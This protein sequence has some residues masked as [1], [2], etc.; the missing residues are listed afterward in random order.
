MESNN[1][2]NQV[3]DLL[4]SQLNEPGSSYSKPRLRFFNSFQEMNEADAKEMASMS[5]V[6]HL[7]H[8]NFFLRQ[9]FSGELEQK[10]DLKIHFK[11]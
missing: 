8:V 2:E 5:G 6:E 9:L 10:M 1:E 11:K 7:M 3:P 4:Q